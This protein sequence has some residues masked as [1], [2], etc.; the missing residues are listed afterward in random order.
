MYVITRE[1]LGLIPL[2]S[3]LFVLPPKIQSFLNNVRKDP[4]N[5]EPLLLTV[6]LHPDALNLDLGPGSKLGELI[7]MNT[8]GPS[9]SAA[10]GKMVLGALK[11]ILDQHKQDP[12][13]RRQVEAE[14][15]LASQLQQ[16]AAKLPRQRL[17][18]LLLNA[19]L[20]HRSSLTLVGRNFA[21][22]MLPAL[23]PAV[24]R[25]KVPET[26]FFN[27][28]EFLQKLFEALLKE[29]AFKQRVVSELWNRT[30]ALTKEFLRKFPVAARPFLIEAALSSQAN[31]V[32][33]GKSFAAK[34]LPT[35]MASSLYERLVGSDMAE[36]PFGIFERLGA[37]LKVFAGEE[38]RSDRAFDRLVKQEQQRRQLKQRQKRKP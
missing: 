12:R 24:S 13:F 38:R 2:P 25:S 15:N 33:V 16:T 14:Y 7:L 37:H 5:F 10:V 8:T 11:T 28:G 30:F 19:W 32:Q 3:G 9:A 31:Q 18:P 20:G 29:P 1:R 17:E 34:M 35:L 27:L 22:Q 26:H 6:E 4:K 23:L 21:S 36:G